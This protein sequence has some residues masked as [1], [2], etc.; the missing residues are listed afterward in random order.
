MTNTDLKHESCRPEFHKSLI[1]CLGSEKE[2]KGGLLKVLLKK[3]SLEGALSADQNSMIEAAFRPNH[4]KRKQFYLQAGEIC[5]CMAFLVKGGVRMFAK[6]RCQY[7]CVIDIKTED[8][9]IYDPESFINQVAS[10]FYF[11]ALEDS[12]LLVIEKSKLDMLSAAIPAFG[13]LLEK[14]YEEA[15]IMMQTRI[16]NR[17]S[18][19]AEERFTDFMLS[20]PTAVN[21]F[22][23]VLIASY[24]GITPET[25]S[26]IRK[27]STLKP[28]LANTQSKRILRISA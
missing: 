23:Q 7:E 9:W 10:K 27:L 25:L 22:P 14:S 15:L 26:R 3:I 13:Q 18:L 1:A 19:S 28:G 24:L 21:R 6:E 17:L 2:S 16:H 12:K 20:N 5:R 11:E 8:S 4:L